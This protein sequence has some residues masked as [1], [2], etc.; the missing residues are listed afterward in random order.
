M[1]HVI[2]VTK[3]LRLVGIGGWRLEVWRYG[4][5]LGVPSHPIG[6]P[7]TPRGAS[8]LAVPTTGRPEP[9]RRAS[10]QG[11]C[12]FPPATLQQIALAS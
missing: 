8:A 11:H 9:V 1:A 2:Q 3:L 4:G 10:A 12:H 5:G 6:L 7:G